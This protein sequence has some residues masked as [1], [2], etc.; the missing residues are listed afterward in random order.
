[1]LLL[2]TRTERTAAQAALVQSEAARTET[3]QLARHR[4]VSVIALQCCAR[5][6]AARRRAARAASAARRRYTA[7]AL[8]QRMWRRAQRRALRAQQ[9]QLATWRHVTPY[10]TVQSARTVVVAALAASLQQYSCRNPYAGGTLWRLCRVLGCDS[11]A[12]PLLRA[13]GIGTV[14]ELAHRSDKDLQAA[15]LKELQGGRGKVVPLSGVRGAAALR[16]A[17]LLLAAP[18]VTL[19]T[20]TAPAVTQLLAECSALRDHP[21]AAPGY[22]TKDSAVRSSFRAAYGDGYAS[23]EEAVVAGLR[24]TDVTAAQLKRFFLLHDT[25]GKAKEAL[26]ELQQEAQEEALAASHWDEWRVTTALWHVTLAADKLPSLLRLPQRELDSTGGAST[27]QQQQQQQQRPA[28]QLIAELTEL[29]YAV[30]KLPHTRKLHTAALGATI[31][32]AAAAAQSQIALLTAAQQLL[33]QLAAGAAAAT[34]VQKALLRKR[35]ARAAAAAAHSAALAKH[36]A[37]YMWGVTHD[38]V[39]AEWTA[40]RA[41]EAAA[42][43]VAADEARHR[44]ERARREA[45]IAA[46][47]V[48]RFGWQYEFADSDDVASDVSG[49]A[50]ATHYGTVY[51]QYKR[52][53]RRRTSADAVP[54]AAV[55]TAAA[56]AGGGS[57]GG[58][59]KSGRATAGVSAFVVESVLVGEADAK[60]LYSYEEDVAASCIGKY[61]CIYTYSLKWTSLCRD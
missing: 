2:A 39:R 36:T 52:V 60:P 19:T 44:A 46:A 40:A 14:S 25:P 9:A 32:T 56:V 7:V 21:L 1:V 13:A 35:R 24:G 15:G 18:A 45:A 28:A 48:L 26:G 53:K 31:A 57:S 37:S 30:A 38:H 10:A 34:G 5:R 42:A 59:V 8:L 33:T 4:T 41:A 51:R 6:W 61:L 17:L 29:V 16:R 11:D 43:V 54:V 50:A 47:G 22:P 23:R 20:V 27:Q 58:V 49:N 55:A 3:L 12:L